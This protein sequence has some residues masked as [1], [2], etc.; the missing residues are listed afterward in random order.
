MAGAERIVL[1]RHQVFT[2][3]DGPLALKAKDLLTSLRHAA[4]AVETGDGG[5]GDVPVVGAG[6]G[7][8]GIEL[9]SDLAADGERFLAGGVGEVEQAV[10]LAVGAQEADEVRFPRCRPS[11]ICRRWR[12][13]PKNDQPVTEPMVTVP[14]LMTPSLP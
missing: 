4:L 1:A 7:A 6:G 14:T 2:Q 3:G 12:F 9:E 8:R 10:D 13:S 11:P 5:D